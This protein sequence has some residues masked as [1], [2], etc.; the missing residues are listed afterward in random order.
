MP[1]HPWL[2]DPDAGP[3]ML[4]ITLPTTHHSSGAVFIAVRA[5][6]L[7]ALCERV[8]RIIDGSTLLTAG[9]FVN[10]DNI[11]YLE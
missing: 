3:V 1:F 10:Y 8:Y 2:A 4:G 9:D 5:V 6:F 11:I 7:L